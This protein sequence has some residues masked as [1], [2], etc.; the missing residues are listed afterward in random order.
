MGCPTCNVRTR[1]ALLPDWSGADEAKIVE[2]AGERACTVC[3]PSA[4][5]DVLSRPTKMFSEDEIAA[6]GA[7][8]AAVAAKAAR[9]AKK[10]E[11]ALTADG[12]ELVIRTP[13]TT[14]YFKTEVA[15][16]NWLVRELGYHEAFRY[17][18]DDEAIAIVL[19]ALATKH[20]VTVE[21]EREAIDA[22]VKAWIKRNNNG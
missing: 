9:D 19:E 14:E 12:S 11:K 21:Q 8:Q 10:I 15:G 5:V 17:D 3:Y 16:R 4:P 20:G 22:R 13:Q 1:F 18:K 7:R 6:Q 2:D